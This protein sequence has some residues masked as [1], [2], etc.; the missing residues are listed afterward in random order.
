MGAVVCD[1]SDRAQVRELAAA[2][3][4]RL[5]G[6]DLLIH[7]AGIQQSLD[8]TAG[9]DPRRIACELDVN[10]L[11]P[12]QVTNALLGR[13]LE[14]REAAIVNVTSVLALAPKQ[15]APVY[16]ASK[17][18][19]AAWTRALRYQ[20]EG[21]ILVTELVPP[22]VDTPMTAG[23]NDAAVDPAVVAQACLRGLQRNQQTIAVG[24]ARVGRALHRV[25]PALLARALR[26]S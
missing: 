6:L 14:S 11:G 23:R 7:C 17:A 13:L 26:H 24:K 3:D 10:L 8:F 1:V 4:E 12:M 20:L 2:V 9:V 21:Q 15:C 18:G 19:L 16:C 5:G 25:A 22:L